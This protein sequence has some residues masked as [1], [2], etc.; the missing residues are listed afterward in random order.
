MD[1]GEKHI[2]R[3]RVLI[4][5]TGARSVIGRDWLAALDYKL[6]RNEKSSE[7]AINA[8]VAECAAPTE[9]ANKKAEELKSE[10]RELFDRNGCIRNYE[11]SVKLKNDAVI[12]QQKGRR[13]PIQLQDVVEK[14]VE[15]LISEG[16]V[17]KISEIHENVFIEPTVITVKKDRSVKVALDDRALNRE[18]VK[19]KYQMPNVDNLI[20]CIAE[21]IERC[22]GQTWF[23]T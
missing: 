5:R 19:D 21:K 6:Q 23:T 20:D 12:T 8:I 13:V 1:V 22:E 3:A 16:Y 10:F 4:S 18:V 9:L 17:E 2:K 11:V 7:N 15:R 14:E